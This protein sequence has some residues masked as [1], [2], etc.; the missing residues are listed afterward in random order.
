[1]IGDNIRHLMQENGYTQKELATRSGISTWTISRYVNNMYA[2][3][4]KARQRL[5]LAL[6]VS[7]DEL[8]NKDLRRAEK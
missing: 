8:S 6:G 2:P 1:M 5:A 4:I 3:G 7:V